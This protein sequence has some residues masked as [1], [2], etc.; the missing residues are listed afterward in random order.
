M[1]TVAGPANA[2]FNGAHMLLKTLTRVISTAAVHDG[3]SEH[4]Q[5]EHGQFDHARFDNRQHG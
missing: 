5:S 3:Q 2:L 1:N 4:G